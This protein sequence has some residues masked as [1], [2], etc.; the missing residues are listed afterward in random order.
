MSKNIEAPV[1]LLEYELE[2]V[3]NRYDEAIKDDN[4][5]LQE[6]FGEAIEYLKKRLEKIKDDK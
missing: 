5:Y 1:K 3:I 2:K 4:P 6:R